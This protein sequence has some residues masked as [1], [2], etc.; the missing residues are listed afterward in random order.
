MQFC[1]RREI[2]LNNCEERLKKVKGVPIELALPPR[3]EDFLPHKDRLADLQRLLYT[4][5]IPVQSV[6]APHGHLAAET[7][8]DWSRV[9]VDFAESVRAPIVVFHPEVHLPEVRR[10]RQAAA[11]LNLKHVQD[12]TKVVIALETFWDA[13]RVMMP[14]EIMEHHIPLVLDTSRIPRSEIT[15]IIES[16]H[17]HIA[18]VHLS[19]MAPGATREDVVKQFRPID[20]DAFCL[21]LLDRLFE[22]EWSG[23][24]TL[25]YMPWLSEKQIEDR[26]L[27][28]RIYHRMPQV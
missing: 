4:L 7:F 28:E 23:V 19:A 10:E 5:E 8:R 15:W 1:I 13:D 9:V 2:D 21:D 11:L 6:H 22:L 17:T 14:D 20:N 18:N 27:L 26:Q 3:L 24:V 16:Y 12:R 25:E